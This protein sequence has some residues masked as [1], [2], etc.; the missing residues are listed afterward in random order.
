MTSS[1]KEAIR[2]FSLQENAAS[3]LQMWAEEITDL[4][5]DS[6]ASRDSYD[7]LVNG[8]PQSAAFLHTASKEGLPASDDCSYHYLVKLANEAD[9]L[10]APLASDWLKWAS[11][12][13]Y[14]APGNDEVETDVDKIKLEAEIL[15][16]PDRALARLDSDLKSLIDINQDLYETLNDIKSSIER[17][18]KTNSK[19][20]LANQ[21]RHVERF[22][23]ADESV[24]K[25]ISYVMGV[26]DLLNK[27]DID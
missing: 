9:K 15:S 2:R 11:T 17:L 16:F 18:E 23:K 25:V 7:D 27:Q 21:G 1:L 26:I 24:S 10:G 5:R 13:C 3:I 4:Y 14:D 20:K 19:F 12:R 8:M 6:D 22:R